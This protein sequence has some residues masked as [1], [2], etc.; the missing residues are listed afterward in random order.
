MKISSIFQR[1]NSSVNKYCRNV[2]NSRFHETMTWIWCKS[3]I[4]MQ[5][6]PLQ[7]LQPRVTSD[8]CSHH[9]FEYGCWSIICVDHFTLF[10]P[11]MML[12]MNYSRFEQEKSQNRI[13]ES[14]TGRLVP[15]CWPQLFLISLLIH[16]LVSQHEYLLCVKRNDANIK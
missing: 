15:C 12:S 2:L 5:A 10:S 14:T 11:V 3:R 6:G 16:F 8:L 13:Q 4:F 1:H 9:Y 7:T